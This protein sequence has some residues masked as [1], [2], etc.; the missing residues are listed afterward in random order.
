MLHLKLS[1]LPDLNTLPTI[2]TNINFMYIE[3]ILT[4]FPW[5][6]Y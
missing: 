1:F 2:G 3:N 5:K 4:T 6:V